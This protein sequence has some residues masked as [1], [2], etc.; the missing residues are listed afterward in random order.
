M[1]TD[2]SPG[3]TQGK[4]GSYVVGRERK[5]EK[6]ELGGEGEAGDF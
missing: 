6:G 3:S 5:R 1:H 2:I 4:Q